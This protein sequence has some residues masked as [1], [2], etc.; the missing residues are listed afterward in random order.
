MKN[1][2]LISVVY[3]FFCLIQITVAAA[4]LV[5]QN[6]ADAFDPG[7]PTK[8]L[9]SFQPGTTLQVLGP[10]P[11]EGFVLVE[12][13]QPNGSAIRAICRKNDVF[14]APAASSVAGQPASAKAGFG[15]SEIYKNVS[16]SL[17]DAKGHLVKGDQLQKLQSS[18]YVLIY[19]SALWCPPCRGFTPGLV[20]NYEK[21]QASGKVPFE[22]IF[23][24]SDNDE[25][26]QLK[27]MKEYKMPWPA[28]R[29]SKVK[30]SPL[31]K[32]GGSGIPNLV[33][34]DKNGSLIKSSYVNGEYYGP[35]SVWKHFEEL[36]NKT[37]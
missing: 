2:F 6:K 31:K 3:V 28:V 26:S 4:P 18:E 17:I 22:L 30:S 24:S 34:L 33:L 23:V 10:A 27:Y 36:Q 8:L 21:A 16:T 12:F 29:L 35:S 19:F 13:Q 1:T 37:K 5:I 15:A 11:Q 9:G 32:F 20:K 7:D 14:A 25:G